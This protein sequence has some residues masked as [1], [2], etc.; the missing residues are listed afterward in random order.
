MTTRTGA[1]VAGD[2]RALCFDV[3]G[4]VVDWR[5]SVAR[6]LESFFSDRDIDRDWPAFADQW[7]A[8]YQ[9]AM[10]DVRRNRR[11]WANLDTLHRENLE[12]VLEQFDLTGLDASDLDHLNRAWHRL[13]PWPDVIP[14]FA[15]LKQRYILASL[16]NGNVAL[17][18]NMAK[19]ADLAW[20][21]VLG[22][23]VAGAYKR[24]PQAYLRS[25]ELLG[26]A[27]EQ[28]MM[29][30]A[31]NDDLIS[32]AGHGFRTAFVCR[33]TE[34]GPDQTTDLVARA[35]FD[36]IASDFGELAAAMGC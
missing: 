20:D 11:P 15:R 22:A 19:R 29:V 7:R 12:A 5:T 36:V 21:V 17:I 33:P 3:F 24:M 25:A 23:E 16:S 1:A 35:E 8:R 4:T 32:A 10:E 28:C 9:P 31:H 2:V 30:A 26:L 13:D 18:V 27:P 6:D 34:H 14:G